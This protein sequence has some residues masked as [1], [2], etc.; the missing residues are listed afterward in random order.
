MIRIPIVGNNQSNP[1]SRPNRSSTLSRASSTRSHSTLSSQPTPAP[2]LRSAPPDAPSFDIPEV[3][4]ESGAPPP[5][6]YAMTDPEPST[7]PPVP[8][9]DRV[10]HG[11]SYGSGSQD[12]AANRRVSYHPPSSFNSGAT[13]PAAAAA[14]SGAGRNRTR[15]D[16]ATP[17]QQQG[18][19]RSAS[20]THQRPQRVDWRN[21]SRGSQESR[22]SAGSGNARTA[23]IRADSGVDAILGNPIRSESP[24][25]AAPRRPPAVPPKRRPSIEDPLELL[26]R[27]D[28]VIIVDD[29]TSMEGPLWYEARDALA[30][31]AEVAARYD[32][33]G[34]DVHF[35]NNP[36]VG[37]GLRNGAEVKRLFDQT[38]PYGI[39]PTGEKLEELLL[40]YLLRLEAAKNAQLQG[41]AGA[42]KRIKPVN[43]LVITDGAA[44]DDPESVIVQAARRLD[45]GHFPLAQVGIQ[46]VQIGTDEDAAEALRVLD[47]DLATTHGVRDIVDTFPYTAEGSQLTADSL[48]KILLGGINHKSKRRSSV[49]YPLKFPSFVMPSPLSSPDAHTNPQRSSGPIPPTTAASALSDVFAFQPPSRVEEVGTPRQ[50]TSSSFSIEP[51]VVTPPTGLSLS[52]LALFNGHR[53]TRSRLPTSYPNTTS[54]LPPFAFSPPASQSTNL[55]ASPPNTGTHSVDSPF[56]YCPPSTDLHDATRG[57]LASSRHL[58]SAKEARIA[59]MGHIQE[60]SSASGSHASSSVSMG[61]TCSSLSEKLEARDFEGIRDKDV[62]IGSRDRKLE[63]DVKSSLTPHFTPKAEPYLDHFDD[64]PYPEVRAS[65]SNTD[66]VEMPCLTFRVLVIGV[67]LCAS[68]LFAHPC[69]VALAW[70]L[71]LRRWSLPP[72]LPIAG[73]WEF[74]LNPSPWTIKEHT[75]V[76]IM[77]TPAINPD[78]GL[79][80]ISAMEKRHYFEVSLG[81]VALEQ[82]VIE[83]IGISL[84][85]L[86]HKILIQPASFIWPSSL[87]YC[88]VLN[89]VHA[90]DFPANGMTRV[91]FFGY[92]TVIAFLYYFLPGFLFTA[93]SYFSFVCWIRP[94]NTVINQLFGTVN[95]LGM[96]LLTFDWNQIA[97]IGSPLMYPFWSQLNIMAG[98]VIF[99]W[100]IIP[101]LYYSDVWK[102][103]HLPISGTIAYDRFAQPYDISRVITPDNNLN[104]T[105]YE[106]YSPLYLPV[107]YVMTYLLAFMLSTALVVHTVLHYG[108]E[109]LR[110]LK[111]EEN[112]DDD[113]HARLMKKYPEVPSWYYWAIFV[114]CTVMAMIAVK[115]RI[116]DVGLPVWAPLLALLVAIIYALPMGYMFA[117][118]GQ[119]VGNNL[120][121]QAIPGRLLPGSALG[122]MIFKGIAVQS[123]TL[124]VNTSLNLK[125]AHYIKCGPKPVFFGQQTTMRSTQRRLIFLIQSKWLALLLGLRLKR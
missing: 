37:Q 119:L 17:G 95:G 64:S 2:A 77:S 20:A 96:G 118:T 46:F 9:R 11:R 117:T 65:V 36:I 14:G 102:T 99:Y 34:I 41:D 55:N 47:D 40:D 32:L 52:E 83:L 110:R 31:I 69:G 67:L 124:M 19:N 51:P 90:G 62:E 98:F 107:T 112:D 111:R 56:G 72:N 45:E 10:S 43:F 57:A 87:V 59:S 76:L 8:P 4:S 1:S 93:L 82:F 26:R 92:A 123:P 80:I 33:D 125:I 18:H 24:P 53:P 113:V 108:P 29:S 85:G 74:S 120:I 30:G 27:Y 105:A 48:S 100:I 39:T 73:G 13:A 49:N 66:D 71:P 97:Y 12:A 35:L 89:T 61:Q 21:G 121:A 115:A 114:G 44:T 81:C 28:T 88:A 22:T 86:T 42:L 5:P 78:Y 79:G 75:L 38:V 103:G 15:S 3:Q 91:Q 68:G 58:P 16:S 25:P 104:V 94:N 84:A 60:G 54:T 116:E 122:N 101:V 6:P 7:P 109:A 63:L 23:F 50:Q 106:E 70:L